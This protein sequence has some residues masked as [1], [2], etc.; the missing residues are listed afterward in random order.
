MLAWQINNSIY[1]LNYVSIKFQIKSYYVNSVSSYKGQRKPLVSPL[2]NGIHDLSYTR[3]K[4]QIPEAIQD[5]Q[6]LL[7]KSKDECAKEMG[8]ASSISNK[9]LLYEDNPTPREK[10]LIACILKKVKLV[11]TEI[12]MV[13]QSQKLLN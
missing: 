7:T 1:N 13:Y 3:S 4:R 5:F 12:Y 9:A 11:R 8:F 10:C 6:D 2:A